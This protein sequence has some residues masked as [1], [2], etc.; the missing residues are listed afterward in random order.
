[1]CE[2]FQ[3]VSCGKNTTVGRCS[4]RIAAMT[5]TRARPVRRIGRAR[6][7]VD[8]L[9]PAGNRLHQVESQVLAGLREL[10]PAP[11]LARLVAALGDRDVHDAV[12][13]LA[14][15]PQRQ[16]ADDALV[17]GVRR[18]DERL[19]CVGGDRRVR[20]IGKPAQ[21]ELLAL[22]HQAA[23]D[24][25]YV[26]YGFCPLIEPPPAGWPRRSPGRGACPSRRAR[27]TRCARR[28]RGTRPRAPR[29]RRRR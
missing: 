6:L 21:R 9:E 24:D 11:L 22:A 13:G 25:T 1:M 27:G 26:R 29:A 23:S 8:L 4:A 14:L 2:L 28:A 5:S 20:G 17:V 12:A 16:A 7:R 18:E 19:R 3:S 10:V 15:Q